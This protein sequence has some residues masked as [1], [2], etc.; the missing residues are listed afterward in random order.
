M[1][2]EVDQFNQEN[3]TFLTYEK[4]AEGLA[5]E[6]KELQ[7]QLADYNTLL[8]KINTDTEMDDIVQDFNALKIQNE[9]EQNSIDEL[10][11]QR[12][13]KEQQIKQLELELD[14]ERRMAESLVED[15]VKLRIQFKF[16]RK[17]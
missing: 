2:K 17:T 4:R 6:I 8:D 16:C 11:T 7:G 3:A 10:F 13:D 9:R 5:T 1:Q 15:M 14:Q 12:R